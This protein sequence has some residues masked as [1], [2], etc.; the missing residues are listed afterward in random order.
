MIDGNESAPTLK[1]ERF[2]AAGSIALGLGVILIL[3]RAL[4]TAVGIPGLPRSWYQNDW[5]WWLVGLTGIAVGA[6]LLIRSE[7]PDAQGTWKPGRPGRRFH[8][9]VLYTRDGCHLCEEA[10]E[11]VQQY[12]RWL[13]PP[14]LVNV[15]SDPKL[16]ERFGTCVPVIALDGK[17]RFRGRVHE[18]LLRR[19]IEGTPPIPL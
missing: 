3:G 18:S 2:A 8:E 1:N 10:A 16:V 9:L 6:R 5:L 17:V 19:L 12:R 4:E 7:S 13:P 15:D 11:T 14:T